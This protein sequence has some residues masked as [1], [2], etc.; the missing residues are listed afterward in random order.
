MAEDPLD[1]RALVANRAIRLKNKNDIG[2]VLRKGPE[3]LFTALE[4]FLGLLSLG[5]ITDNR[6]EG[7]RP[8]VRVPDNG[9]AVFGEERA[10]VPPNHPILHVAHAPGLNGAHGVG[11]GAFPILRPNQVKRVL[12]QELITGLVPVQCRR[13]SVAEEDPAAEVC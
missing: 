10:A 3:V 5:H 9:G 13:P 1:R 11:H 8:A 12:A 7:A 2:E 4:R 6:R